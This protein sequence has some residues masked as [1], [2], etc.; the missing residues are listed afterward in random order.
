ML[1]FLTH[2]VCLLVRCCFYAFILFGFVLYFGSKINLFVQVISLFPTICHMCV[3]L[4]VC[5]YNFNSD[6]FRY[7]HIFQAVIDFSW[8]CNFRRKKI[9]TRICMNSIIRMRTAEIK[10]NLQAFDLG[11]ENECERKKRTNTQFTK[12]TA[13]ALVGILVGTTKLK[14]KFISTLPITCD[15]DCLIFCALGFS[16]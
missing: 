15:W 9:C 2:L 13:R 3:C 5:V 8:N 10:S 16:L 7:H 4:C 11:L 1:L 14:E 12:Q 6:V